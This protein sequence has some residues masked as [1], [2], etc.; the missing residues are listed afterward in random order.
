MPFEDRIRRD[1][2]ATR[3]ASQRLLLWGGAKFSLRCFQRV[4]SFRLDETLLSSA[5]ANIDA[6]ISPTV[7]FGYSIL[8]LNIEIVYISARHGRAGVL[9]CDNSYKLISF[10]CEAGQTDH[11]ATGR[12][13]VV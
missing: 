3:G 4:H 13:Y 7:C 8:L 12:G 11:E 10:G 1:A 5:K 2:I 6:F 9:T